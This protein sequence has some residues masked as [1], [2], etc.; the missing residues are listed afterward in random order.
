MLQRRYSRL[1][2]LTMRPK[3][4]PTGNSFGGSDLNREFAPQVFLPFVSSSIDCGHA[5]IELRSVSPL[6]ITVGKI[7]L[8]VVW[9]WCLAGANFFIQTIGGIVASFS[10][11][12]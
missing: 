11:D 12:L 2:P 5:A 8:C 6:I 3:L 10:P 1:S 4:L 7:F 9:F